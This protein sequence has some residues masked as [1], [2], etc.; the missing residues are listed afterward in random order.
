M[1]DAE[2]YTPNRRDRRRA[3]GKGRKTNGPS[4]SA[5]AKKPPVPPR[6]KAAGSTD[7]SQAEL[8]SLMRAIAAPRNQTEWEDAETPRRE[9]EGALD[10]DPD[11]YADL[12]FQAESQHNV[13]LGVGEP[14]AFPGPNS[15]VGTLPGDTRAILLLSILDPR[16][17]EALA[18]Q[19]YAVRL[20]GVSV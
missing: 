16:A 15:E 8:R 10:L 20:R 19:A 11:E 1:T 9:L 18:E 12:K 2:P 14:G 5:F 13:T 17:A 6:A 4:I 7:P 3:G